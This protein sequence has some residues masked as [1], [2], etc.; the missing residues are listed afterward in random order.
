VTGAGHIDARVTDLVDG[1]LDRD[2]ADLFFAHA[3][4]CATCKAA[5]DAERAVK[6]KLANSRDPQPSQMLRARLVG[7]AAP[8]EPVSP[9]RPTMPEPARPSLPP[10]PGPRST[11]HSRQLTAPPGRGAD[12]DGYHGDASSVRQRRH[13]RRRSLVGVGA[14]SFAG[15]VLAVSF[16]AGAAQEPGAPVTPSTDRFAIEHAATT[17]GLTFAKSELDVMSGF[18]P[19]TTA[20]GIGDPGR[21]VIVEPAQQLQPSGSASP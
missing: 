20:P 16:T 9:R 11:L 13:R 10:V 2:S 4:S 8:G 6:G 15:A 14:L 21:R 5:I 18:M 12:R 7:L 1:R 3:A 17:T 19:V